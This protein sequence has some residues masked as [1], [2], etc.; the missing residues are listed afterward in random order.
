MKKKRV[1]NGSQHN[2][3]DAT[4][5][6]VQWEQGWYSGYRVGTV[7]TGLVHNAEVATPGLHRDKALAVC[8]ESCA[9]LLRF[10]HLEK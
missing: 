10:A 5:G 9:G 4:P 7:G 2:A 1:P 6:L 8:V 3:E